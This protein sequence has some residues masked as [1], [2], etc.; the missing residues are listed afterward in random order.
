MYNNI[1]DTFF[2]VVLDEIKVF[3]HNYV[4]RVFKELNLNG[5]KL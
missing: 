3:I 5:K 4:R 1:N 2:Q